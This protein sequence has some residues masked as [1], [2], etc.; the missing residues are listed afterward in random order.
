MQEIEIVLFGKGIG[1]AILI[2]CG[3]DHWIAVDS[4]YNSNKVPAAKAFFQEKG[5]DHKKLIKK[6]VISHFHNDHIKGMG[7]L[8]SDCE[9]A[10]VFISDALSLTEATDFFA[11]HD[12]HKS[13]TRNESGISEFLKV[14]DVLTKRQK[15]FEHVIAN[16]LIHQ[17]INNPI[18]IF[19][20][21]PSS[22]DCQDR[23]NEFLKLLKETEKGKLPALS[24]KISNH[25]CLTLLVSTAHSQS[26]GNDILL[27]ADLEIKSNTNS[28]WNAAIASRVSPKNTAKVFKIPHHG[29]DTGF[30][31]DTWKVCMAL[32]PI[33]IL[34]TFSSGKKHLPDMDYIKAYSELTE[35]LYCTTKPTC[36]RKEKL[37]REAKKVQSIIDKNTPSLK[38]ISK[39]SSSF[40]SIHL[41]K[42]DNQASFDV[43]LAGDAQCLKSLL[44]A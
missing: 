13:I 19:S 28:G 5:L 9:D 4:C 16:T 36:F 43:S 21:S 6:I 22:F 15:R 18:Q 8:I 17:C 33:G 3:D 44:S 11:Y 39:V 30:H 40:G 7:E 12:C 42:C 10:D 26:R 29:S 41:K 34:T 35:Q 24:K 25:N 20:M 14:L 38:V 27:G 2:N 23:R 32:E 37:T 31:L 1:E